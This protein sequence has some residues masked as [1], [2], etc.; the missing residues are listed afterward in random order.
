MPLIYIVANPPGKSSVLSQKTQTNWLCRLGLH[1]W[2]DFGESVVVTWTEPSPGMGRL[3]AQWRP[4]VGEVRF[5]QDSRNVFTERECLRCG[6]A[7]K[8]RIVTNFDG[9]LSCVGWEQ[10]PSRTVEANEQ[11]GEQRRRRVR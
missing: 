6:I 10:V 5:D 2:R 11:N 8:R 9:T 7:M 1:K 3:Q 4:Y